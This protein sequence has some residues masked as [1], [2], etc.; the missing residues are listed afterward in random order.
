M[1]AYMNR[2][3]VLLALL[4]L[5]GSAA[6]QQP[7]APAVQVAK[8]ELKS[9]TRSVTATGQVRSRAGADLAAGVAGRLAWVAEPGTRVT[10]GALV[11]KLDLDE[12]R[13]QRV[14]QAARVTRGELALRAA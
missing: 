3:F 5:C 9:L 11:A 13:L 10:K 12:M 6:A 8:A 14:E 7:H 4:A 2:K 1:E